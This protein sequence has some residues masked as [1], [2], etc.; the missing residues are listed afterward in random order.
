ML[1]GDQIVVVHLA[2]TSLPRCPDSEMDQAAYDDGKNSTPFTP[3]P[4]PERY[5]PQQP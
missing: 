1:N 4:L 5:I 3:A 2:T